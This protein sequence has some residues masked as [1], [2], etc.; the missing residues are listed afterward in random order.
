MIL[1]TGGAGFIGSVTLSY[2]N[3]RGVND[4]IVVDSFDKNNNEKWKN[5]VG[6]NFVD[7]Y[8]KEKILEKL[9]TFNNIDFIIHLGACTDTTNYDVNFLLENNF[10][11]SKTLCSY[12][13]DKSIPF[14]HASSAATYG[15][16]EFGFNDT[17]E[18]F[19]KLRPL[20]PYGFSKQVFD[21][22]FMKNMQKPIKWA[23]LKFFNVY[24][25]NEYHKGK[26]A[27]MVYQIYNQ[28]KANG[29]VKLFKSYVEKV[30]YGEQKRDFIYVEDVAKIIYNMF[31]NGFNNS[32][33]NVG[34]GEPHSFN[35]LAYLIMKFSGVNGKIEYIDI[36][37]NIKE[38]YQYYTLANIENLLSNK[39]IDKFTT[40]ECG[41]ENYI[42]NYLQNRVKYY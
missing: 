35:E 34:T 32:L 6:K 1:L 11:F 37:D 26:M 28:L 3:K 4:I 15:S 27:S 10:N 18:N 23:I 25:P 29:F 39:I 42:K 24:G 16:G 41:V 13:I 38:N 21:M 7:L 17:S 36:P 12:A 40:L 33:F 5:L 20:N 8:D 2:F 19:Y 30:P 31:Q 22:W 9:P 14:I